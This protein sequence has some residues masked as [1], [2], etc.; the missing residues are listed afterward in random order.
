MQFSH[1]NF[2]QN[3][4]CDKLKIFQGRKLKI[5]YERQDKNIFEIKSIQ[6]FISN[7]SQKKIKTG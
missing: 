6:M 5:L 2:T 7:Y 1:L 3:S 4:D